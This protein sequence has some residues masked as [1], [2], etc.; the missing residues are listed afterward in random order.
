MVKKK[1][2]CKY[3]WW[4]LQL[5]DLWLVYTIFFALQVS[6]LLK[7]LCV[8]NV[9]HL[10]A[11]NKHVSLHLKTKICRRGNLPS[12]TAQN[13]VCD[14]FYFYQKKLQLLWFDYCT[15]PNCDCDYILISFAVLIEIQTKNS[16]AGG[17]NG[18][19]QSRKSSWNN[20]FCVWT[21]IRHQNTAQCF[22]ILRLFFSFNIRKTNIPSS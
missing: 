13:A 17:F 15:P 6:L 14:I 16:P 7:K 22:V 20:R 10:S 19:V 21:F 1:S 5:Y 8:T 2:Y 11:P 9:W 4:I 12:M 3:F 18:E